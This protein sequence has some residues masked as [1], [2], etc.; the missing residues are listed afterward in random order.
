MGVGGDVL[1]ES[2]EFSSDSFNFVVKRETKSHWKRH[3][4]AGERRDNHLGEWGS[5]QERMVTWQQLRPPLKLWEW[6]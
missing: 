3:S 2:V 4:G 6:I 5:R 1:V